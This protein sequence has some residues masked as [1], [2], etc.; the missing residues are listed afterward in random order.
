MYQIKIN[1]LNNENYNYTTNYK[2][3]IVFNTILLVSKYELSPDQLYQ[4]AIQ[5]QEMT[6][7]INI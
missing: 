6:D 3:F 2:V 5:K 7:R 1:F 4:Y